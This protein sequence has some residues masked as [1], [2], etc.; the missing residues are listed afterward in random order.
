MDDNLS[1]GSTISRTQT[2]QKKCFGKVFWML[3]VKGAFLFPPNCLCHTLD[4]ELLQ[5]L[6][7]S[8]VEGPLNGTRAL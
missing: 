3:E 6:T 5:K 7:S 8:S 2:S 1:L 4:T